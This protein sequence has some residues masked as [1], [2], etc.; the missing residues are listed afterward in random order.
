M[1]TLKITLTETRDFELIPFGRFRFTSSSRRAA[2]EGIIKVGDI[3]YN[4]EEGMP[5]PNDSRESNAVIKMMLKNKTEVLTN[6]Q[7][8]E[9]YTRLGKGL[10][11]INHPNIRKYK[12]FLFERQLQDDYVAWLI[13]KNK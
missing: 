3:S 9:F 2:H 4:Y 12:I 7:R 6:V 5:M 13:F 10:S 8:T 1:E 11:K